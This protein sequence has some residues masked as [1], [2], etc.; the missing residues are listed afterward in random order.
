MEARVK[1]RRNLSKFCQMSLSRH[2]AHRCPFVVSQAFV[3]CLGSFYYWRQA[4]ERELICR[5]V[6]QVLGLEGAQERKAQHRRIFQGIFRHYQEKLFLAY[7]PEAKV[8]AFLS[9][10][11]E[12]RGREELEA[13]LRGGRGVLMVTGHYGAVEFLPAALSLRGYPVA[14]I[15]R[16]Q[17]PELAASMAKRAALVNLNLIIPENGKVL[18]AALRALKAGRILI[19]EMDE[20]EMW[21]GQGEEDRVN[22][23]GFGIPGD[24]TLDV[25]QK[26][27]QAPVL[28][29]LVQ[30]RPRRHY[31]V[32][33]EP[34]AWSPLRDRLSSLCLR[35][36]EQAVWDHPEQWYQWK[37][38]GK[39]VT[40]LRPS[41]APA[42]TPIL[43]PAAGSV[44]Q[45]AHA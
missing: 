7:A 28:T 45:Y 3:S 4:E 38:F 42:A 12:L 13:A 32:A 30:R 15:V 1:S 2:L 23:L 44:G 18:P 27:A 43:I 34:V 9:R 16:P 22:F 6:D 10:R 41:P 21:R 17:T 19:T 25:L 39:V 11:L 35:R 36:L 31:T 40:A 5:T 8:K 33:M 37:E 24:R 26:R 20:F 29:A 14:V